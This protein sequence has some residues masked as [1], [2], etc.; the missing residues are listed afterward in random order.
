MIAPLPG[1]W[2]QKPG[3]ASLPFFGVDPVIVNEKVGYLQC[4]VPAFWLLQIGEHERSEWGSLGSRCVKFEY[5][6]KL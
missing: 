4:Q 5:D 3:S 6:A 1:V 2:A